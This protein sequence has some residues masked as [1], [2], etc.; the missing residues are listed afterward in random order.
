MEGYIALI[1][2]NESLNFQFLNSSIGLEPSKMVKKGEKS[3]VGRVALGD[4]WIY[5]IHFLE[6]DFSEKVF[7][8]IDILDARKDIINKVKETATVEIAFYIVSEMGQFGYALTAEQLKQ[9]SSFGVNINFDLLSYGLV[10]KENGE[11]VG[12]VDILEMAEK[13]Y[14]KTA[15]E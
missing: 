6:D 7:K 14:T 4:R 8:F 12:L 9:F 2:E 10:E 5:D 13:K 15:W 1:I 3:K 11:M